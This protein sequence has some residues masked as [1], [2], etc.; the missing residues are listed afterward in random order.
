[1]ERRLAEA[2]SDATQA[3]ATADHARAERR[4]LEEW[5]EALKADTAAAEESLTVA[6]EALAVEEV[7][8]DKLAAEK[9]VLAGARREA[10]E[11]V[12][13][14]VEELAEAQAALALRVQLRTEEERDEERSRAKASAVQ[15]QL[16]EVGCQVKAKQ[17]ELEALASECEERA[18]LSTDATDRHQAELSRLQEE[19]VTVDKALAEARANAA[20]AS[21]KVD[22]ARVQLRQLE[23]EAE[24]ARDARTRE[25]AG[26]LDALAATATLQA[27]LSQAQA[28]EA[29][30]HTRARHQ[31]RRAEA[32]R[33]HLASLQGCA[34]GAAASAA[35]ERRRAAAREADARLEGC[36]DE[37][38]VLQT[39]AATGTDGDTSAGAAA[40]KLLGLLE[41]VQEQRDA[42]RREAE[43]LDSQHAAATTQVA[44]GAGAG[45]GG[46]TSG[47]ALVELEQLAAAN[48]RLVT[49]I[50]KQ[51]QH[52]KAAAERVQ[53]E[54]AR[55][56]A[57]QVY[58][59]VAQL[60][61]CR[62][63]IDGTVGRRML[64]PRT[65][66]ALKP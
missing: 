48:A 27:S 64:V 13:R 29:A 15:R 12:G 43:L 34:L 58:Y 5:A 20:Q 51:G 47:A 61:G 21:A 31:A 50:G 2:I 3:T 11:A 49:D 28:E 24:A 22:C 55:L 37:L 23:A 32:E 40:T 54:L 36:L 65:S 39:R 66:P 14:A 42:V 56:Q 33:A 19:C 9:E 26:V 18:R 41:L 52:L 7:A 44:S 63:H 16:E 45:P 46:G 8:K 62:W 60:G 30:A 25:E 6:M 10:E 1:M 38:T 53:G 17:A 59:S 4:H 57:L 35:T